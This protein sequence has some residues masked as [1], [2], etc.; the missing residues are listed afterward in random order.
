[1]IRSESAIRPMQAL[2]ACRSRQDGEGF[3]LLHR[4]DQRRRNKPGRPAVDDQVRELVVWLA[5]ENPSWGYDRIQGALA[6]LGHRIADQTVGNILKA[7]GVESAPERQ[8]QTTMA[9]SLLDS[10]RS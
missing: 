9:S 3:L 8:R 2:D 5:R 1:M 7:H 4:D 6:N 10:R